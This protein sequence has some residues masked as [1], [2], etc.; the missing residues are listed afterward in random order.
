ME[1]N[2]FSNFDYTFSLAIEYSNNKCLEYISFIKKNKILWQSSLALYL[3]LSL[4]IPFFNNYIV[5]IIYWVGLGI[6]ST[7]GLGT[8]VHTGM[9]FLFPYILSI[10]D[11]ALECNNTNFYLLGPNKFECLDNNLET[12]THGTIFLKSLPPTILW[13]LGATIGEIPP[14]YLA[15]IAS[16]TN[17]ESEYYIVQKYYEKVLHFINKYGFRTILLLACWPNVTFDICGMASGYCGVSFQNFFIATFIGKGLIKAPLEAYTILF[18][19]DKEYIDVKKFSMFIYIY[20]IIFG[21]TILYFIKSIIENLAQKQKELNI[22]NDKIKWSFYKAILNILNNLNN[23]E[24][25]DGNPILF[26]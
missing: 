7:I 17:F 16:E 5:F 1:I 11:T 23:I 6:L 10:K 24:D 20:N 14:Y 9:F 15:K 18:L 2:L 3:L 12:I 25:E 4:V 8:G 19:Y 21:I 22:D 26:L 13:G